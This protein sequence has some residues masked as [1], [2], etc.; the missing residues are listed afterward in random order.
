MVVVDK[1]QF[2]SLPETIAVGRAYLA[3]SFG[4]IEDTV[5]Y[6]SQ[7]L[8]LVPEGILSGVHRRPCFWG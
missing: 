2:K 3:Q 8:E 1:E 6:A 7:V 4:N 5:R